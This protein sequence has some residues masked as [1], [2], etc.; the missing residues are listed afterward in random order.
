MKFENKLRMIF[1]EVEVGFQPIDVEKANQIVANQASNYKPQQLI[2]TFIPEHDVENNDFLIVTPGQRLFRYKNRY[3]ALIMDSL[4]A[5]EEFPQRGRGVIA[6][7]DKD[8]TTEKQTYIVIPF[9]GSQFGMSPKQD[10]FKSFSNVAI[11]LGIKFENFNDSL[12][13]LLNMFS[14]P[15][16]TYDLNSKKF[17]KLSINTYNE[18]YEIFK[19]A[20]DMV[21][22][23]F[24]DEKS[25]PILDEIINH[26]YNKETEDNTI[27]II[28]Y[29]QSKEVTLSEML[30][31]LFEPY[32][33]GFKLIT[34]KNFVLGEYKDR[35]MWTDNKCLLVKETALD[36]LQLK[37]KVETLPDEPQEDP[38]GGMGGEEDMGAEEP[39]TEPE[40]ELELAPEEPSMEEPAPSGNADDASREDDVENEKP[41]EDEEEFDF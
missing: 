27:S 38:M 28:E 16:G 15:K 29:L 35:D 21:D 23:H 39:M 18:T 40:P 37:G 10:I 13:T 22:E 11:N 9:N 20:V 2:Y 36:Q 33:N 3:H 1:E 25:A 26:P 8:R 19:R 17:T 41:K 30:D 5:W 32:E 14:N 24:F 12:N 34:F 31:T 6:T 4:E 7:S